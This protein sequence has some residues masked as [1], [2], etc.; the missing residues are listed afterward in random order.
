MDATAN[1]TLAP[2]PDIYRSSS[3][4]GVSAY[5][6]EDPYATATSIPGASFS[7]SH[8]PA[9]CADGSSISSGPHELRYE[10]DGPG[11]FTRD[12]FLVYYGGVDGAALWDHAKVCDTDE[13]T[14]SLGRRVAFSGCAGISRKCFSCGETVPSG[15][16]LFRDHLN[17]EYECP[18]APA[19]PPDSSGA[20]SGPC[21]GGSGDGAARAGAF[22]ANANGSD[23]GAVDENGSVRVGVPTAPDTGVTPRRPPFFLPHRLPIPPA[24][25][26]ALGRTA[27]AR[28]PT[29]RAAR[30]LTMAPRSA[31]SVSQVSRPRRFRLRSRICPAA[32]RAT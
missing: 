2:N 17:T 15:N 4:G 20:I 30:T 11:H 23:G 3:T 12:D 24:P 16:A 14:A 21:T 7:D 18:Y 25:T 13:D 9:S 10:E 29:T 6:L 26:L 1:M 22:L 8:G 32:L 27:R 5:S 28:A 31:R 19:S